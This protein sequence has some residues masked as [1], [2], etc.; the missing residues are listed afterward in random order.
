MIDRFAAWLVYGLFGLDPE[1]RL[2][3]SVHFFFYDTT[4]IL[5]LLFLISIL[6]GI[7]NAYFP[8]AGCGTFLPRAASSACNTSSP[9]FSEPSLRS[10]PAR[11]SPSSSDSSREGSR[12]A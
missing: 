3:S 12:S 9:R 6:M 4:K 2:G 10:A 11:R 5:L 1:S 8:S 7:I